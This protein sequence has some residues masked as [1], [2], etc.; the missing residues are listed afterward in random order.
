MTFCKTTV[1]IKSL[2]MMI[3]SKMTDMITVSIITFCTALVSIMTYRMTTISITFCITLVSIMTFIMTTVTTMTHSITT[4][5]YGRQH[6]ITLD[7]Y[8]QHI[9]T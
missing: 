2:I 1:S 5:H 6:Y 8:T 4:L 7:E 9:D 3:N